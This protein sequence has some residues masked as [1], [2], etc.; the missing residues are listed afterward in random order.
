MRKTILTLLAASVIA[1][2]SAEIAA[3]GQ[4]H[5]V[6]KVGR[7]PVAEQFRNANNAIAQ[8]AQPIWPYSGYSAPAGQ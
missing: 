7:A 3:A 1:A 4:H 5:P 6:H 2:S 8:P